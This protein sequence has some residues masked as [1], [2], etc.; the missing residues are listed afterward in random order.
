MILDFSDWKDVFGCTTFL[1]RFHRW[2]EVN[3][4]HADLDLEDQFSLF[5]NRQSAG[6]T[7]FEINCD[8]AFQMFCIQECVEG[9]M[10]EM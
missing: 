5:Y 2:R 4:Q 3:T 8:F 7:Q 1:E 9:L 10:E 6:K